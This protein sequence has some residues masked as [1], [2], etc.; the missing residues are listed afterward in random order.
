MWLRLLGLSCTVQECIY[1]YLKHIRHLSHVA[2][3][4]PIFGLRICGRVRKVDHLEPIMLKVITKQVNIPPQHVQA[5]AIGSENSQRPPR[6]PGF[7][8]IEEKVERLAP[9]LGGYV[10]LLTCRVVV[11]TLA[12]GVFTLRDTTCTHVHALSCSEAAF[13]L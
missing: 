2:V 12:A 8:V 11:D 10:Q 6:K 13:I 7:L 9:I 4:S 5:I 3:T 1:T